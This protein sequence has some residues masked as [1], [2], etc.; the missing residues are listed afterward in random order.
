MRAVRV[1]RPYL[2]TRMRN[3]S[4]DSQKYPR[5]S[6]RFCPVTGVVLPILL[7]DA[8]H[9]H[10]GSRAKIRLNAPLISRSPDAPDLVAHCEFVACVHDTIPKPASDFLRMLLVSPVSPDPG[11]ANIRPYR[12]RSESRSRPKL[13]PL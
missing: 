13:Q 6:G 12:E 8:D 1:K 9:Q 5:E 3:A 4:I 11:F 10:S 7:A 2:K